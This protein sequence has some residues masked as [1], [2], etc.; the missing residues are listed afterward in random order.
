MGLFIPFLSVLPLGVFFLSSFFFAFLIEV[1]LPSYSRAS[2]LFVFA[3]A[4]VF[5]LSNQKQEMFLYGGLIASRTSNDS[6]AVIQTR[7]NQLF[8]FKAQYPNVDIYLSA[9]VMRIPSYNGD[10]EEPW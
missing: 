8:A 7:L 1:L 3:V 9:V 6:E 4:L 5:L 2:C 10:E